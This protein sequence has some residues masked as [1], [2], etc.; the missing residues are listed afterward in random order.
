MIATILGIV[1]IIGGLGFS[2]M[3]VWAAGR[4][5]RQTTWRENVGTPLIG[6]GVALL[7]VAILIWG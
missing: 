5:S 1:L 3:A 6:V 2:V 4:A 7:G